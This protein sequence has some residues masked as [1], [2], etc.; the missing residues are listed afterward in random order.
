MRVFEI[1]DQLT[2]ISDVVD[3]AELVTTTFNG[4]PSSW[5]RFVQGICARRKLPKFDKLWGDCTQ[6]EEDYIL[7]HKED[8]LYA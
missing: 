7:R 3:D 5:D 2:I 1:R 4:F 8:V 6:E